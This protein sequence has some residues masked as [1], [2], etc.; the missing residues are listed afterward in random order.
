MGL[1]KEIGGSVAFAMCGQGVA[2]Y[3]GRDG[4]EEDEER[5]SRWSDGVRRWVP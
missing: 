5:C 2:E 1:E 3:E 4:G